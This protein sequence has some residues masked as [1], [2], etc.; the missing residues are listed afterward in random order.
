MYMYISTEC[1]RNII[2]SCLGARVGLTSNA[3]V[4]YDRY[5]SVQ[6]LPLFYCPRT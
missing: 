4:K 1:K 3:Q 5:I 2:L 6:I